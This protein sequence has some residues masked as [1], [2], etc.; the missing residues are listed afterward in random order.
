MVDVLQTTVTSDAGP[1]QSSPEIIH[2]YDAHDRFWHIVPD[3][4]WYAW[5]GGRMP[6]ELGEHE[7]DLDL[8]PEHTTTTHGRERDGNVN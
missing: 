4:I 5:T 2:T 8:P 6:T 3:L 1:D 7:I